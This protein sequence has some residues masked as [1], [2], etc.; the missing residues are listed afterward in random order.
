M[1]NTELFALGI[2]FAVAAAAAAFHVLRVCAVLVGAAA[3]DSIDPAVAAVTAGAESAFVTG[4]PVLGALQGASASGLNVAGLRNRGVVGA[5]GGAFV[6]SA[7]SSQNPGGLA[8]AAAGI[9]AQAIA[10]Q[11]VS[12]TATV[13]ACYRQRS[14]SLKV[15]P[16]LSETRC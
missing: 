12:E 14:P 6:A 8:G 2:V 10:R 9:S 11:Q 1:D 15:E 4:G 16:E 3:A 5:A 13:E 7:V